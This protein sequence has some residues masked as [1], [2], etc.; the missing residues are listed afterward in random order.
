METNHFM[1]PTL[2]LS[3]RRWQAQAGFTLI[4]MMVVVAIVGI[5]VAIAVPG[6]QKL[7]AKMNVSSAT[8]TILG[9]FKQARHLAISEG[10]SVKVVFSANK[11]VFDNGSSKA[12]EVNMVS[13]GNVTLSASA[14][15]TFASR[16]TANNINVT[17][18]NGS[19]CKKI[20][21]NSIG[22]TYLASPPSPCP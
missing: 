14:D 10:R 18:S 5:A 3:V 9:H 22:R 1:P 19:I 16:G 15:I 11:Y 17:I 21:V 8:S 12:R 4:E 7:R 20:I 6:Y 2:R 13:F